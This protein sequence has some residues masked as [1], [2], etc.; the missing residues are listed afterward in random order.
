VHVPI[1]SIDG[2]IV[3]EQQATISI[4]DRGFL[5]GD[6]LFETFRTWECVAVDWPEHEARLRGSAAALQLRVGAIDVEGALAAAGPGEQRVKVIVTRGPGAP[7]ARFGT[8]GGGRTIVIVEPLGEVKGTLSACVVDLPLAR[9]REAHK[10]LAYVE[11]LIARELA[12]PADEAIRLDEEGFVAEGA[13]SNVFVVEGG[14]AY[15]PPLDG[16]VLAGVTRAQ[17]IGLGA[18]ERKITLAEL[19]RAEEVF[20]TSAI[21]GVAAITQLDGESCATGQVTADLASRYERAMRE[22]AQHFIS[23]RRAPD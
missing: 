11:N 6:G 10:A 4:F 1:V 20:V 7:G 15:T 22:R 13:M 8:L 19:R 5:Y 2:V 3:P 21:R 18:R 23:N 14:V 16:G 9:R 17:V 12:A